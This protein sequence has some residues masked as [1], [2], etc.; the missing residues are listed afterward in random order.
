MS[1]GI[2][3]VYGRAV[4]LLSRSA[5]FVLPGGASGAVTHDEYTRDFANAGVTEQGERPGPTAWMS[6]RA[7][8]SSAHGRPRWHPPRRQRDRRP[9]ATQPAEDT[10]GVAS[11]AAD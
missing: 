3:T 7:R 5:A 10:G 2:Q 9:A 11:A 4:R 1:V 6:V 8:R